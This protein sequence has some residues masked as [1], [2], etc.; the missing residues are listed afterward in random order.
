MSGSISGIVSGLHEAGEAIRVSRRAGATAFRIRSA[1][2][3]FQR[4][5]I[6]GEAGF[7]GIE[8]K[9]PAIG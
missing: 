2:V 8:I 7:R 5:E 4:F 3:G 9:L 6:V 1:V